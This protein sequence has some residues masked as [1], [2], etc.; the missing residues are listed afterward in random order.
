MRFLSLLFLFFICT[1]CSFSPLY[2]EKPDE[3]V[4]QETAQI[5]I[6]PIE[7]VLG[8]TLR[9]QLNA[10]LQTNA[11]EPSKYTL[12]ITIS[13]NI[14]GDL[15]IQKTNFATRSR[16][17]LT[18]HY[19]LKDRQTNQVLLNTDTSASGSYNL[20]TAYST[21]TAQDKMRQNL[22]K[23]LA[24]NI[25]IRLSMYFKKQEAS[26]ESAKISN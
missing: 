15:G 2:F 25:S 24:D 16:L 17:I 1:A 22:A 21:M 6:E 8:Y 9:D 12:K 14:I 20:T 11:S 7:G 19:I 26:F 13:E 18:A 3:N 23:I 5:Q 10:K 4:L